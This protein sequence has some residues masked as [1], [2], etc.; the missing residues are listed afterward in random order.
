MWWWGR[1]FGVG[2]GSKEFWLIRSNVAPYLS[3]LSRLILG[4]RIENSQKN[5]LLFQ[6]R[7]SQ[8]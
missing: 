3:S 8:F 6:H 1:E 7:K 5:F 4:D 2:A